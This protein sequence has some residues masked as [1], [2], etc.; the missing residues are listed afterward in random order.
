MG[1]RHIPPRMVSEDAAWKVVYLFAIIG[2]ILG[3]AAG[4]GASMAR[5]FFY[6][7]AITA[8]LGGPQG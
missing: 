1:D 3:L 5:T 4:G 7:C 6:P 2:F 8:H